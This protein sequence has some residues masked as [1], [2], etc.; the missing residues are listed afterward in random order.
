MSL[1]VVRPLVTL[2]PTVDTGIGDFGYLNPANAQD[3]NAGTFASGQPDGVQGRTGES[4]SGFGSGPSP[5]T[6]VN[7]K[8]TSA[9]NCVS[10]FAEGFALDYSLNGGGTWTTLYSMGVYGGSCASLPQRTDVVS[11]NPGQ[12]LT[13]VQVRAR[14]ASFGNTTHQVYD[15]WIEAQ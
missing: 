7:L 15:A 3:G 13:Q 9:G 11:I 12:D 10:G 14:F 2:R 1:T 4:W 8:I 6:T 5:R